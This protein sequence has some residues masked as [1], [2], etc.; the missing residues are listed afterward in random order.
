MSHTKP[1][2]GAEDQHARLAEEITS[3]NSLKEAPLRRDVR[4]LGRILGMVLQEQEGEAL[5]NQVEELRKLAT[6][7]RESLDDTDAADEEA[8]LEIEKFVAQLSVDET[9]RI[10]KAFSTYFE[11]TNLAETNHRKRRLRAARVIS[12]KSAPPGSMDG[13]LER[14]KRS[15]MTPEDALQWLSKVMVIPTFTAHPT[16]VAR[17]TVLY[18][19]RQIAHQIEQIDWFPLTDQEAS[20]REEAITA[21]VTELWQ[22]DEVRRRAPI[23]RDE[24]RM[25]LDY[26]PHALIATI[27]Q[28]YRTIANS[29]RAVYDYEV[30][31]SQLPQVVKFGSWIGGD[32]DGNPNVTPESTREALQ[33]ARQT[34]IAHYIIQLEALIEQISTSLQRTGISEEFRAKYEEYADS[35]RLPEH[36]VRTRSQ[37]ELYRHFFSHVRQKLVATLNA[38]NNGCYMSAKE[39][40]DDLQLASDSL[41]AFNGKRLSDFHIAPLIRQVQTFGFHLH[42]LDIRQHARVH[43]KAIAELTNGNA[44]TLPSPSLPSPPSD[45]TAR[46]LET[47]RTIADLKRNYPPESITQYV[48]SGAQSRQDVLSLIWLMQSCSIQVS[49]TPNDPGIMPVPLFESIADLRN[50]PKI[51]R[52][53][54]QD[55]DFA[56][57]L[58]SWGRKQEVMLGYSDSNKDGGM[59]TSTWEIFKAHRDLHIAARECDVKLRLFHGRG[60]TVGRGGGPTHRAITAQP[61]GGFEG[62]LR[63]TEQGEVLNWKYADS[64][65]AGRNLEL[66]VAAGLEALTR[67]GGWGAAIHQE[68]ESTMD[69]LSQ[70]A[71][72]YYRE[73]IVDNPDVLTYFEQATPVGELENARIGSRPSRRS[74]RTNLEDLRAIP[75]VFGWMQSRHVTP[76]YFGVGYALQ[77]FY[78]SNGKA[79]LELFQ[80]MLLQFPLFEDLI[81]NVE[82]ALAKADL[83]IAHRYAALV[84]DDK[85]RESVYTLLADELLR[86]K[87]M[88]LL[89]TGQKYLLENNHTLTNSI[90]LRNPYIDPMSVI[91]GELLRRKR[92]G[93]GSEELN[94]SLGSTING[95]SSGLRNTG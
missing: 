51:C 93:Q 33:M 73:N 69:T 56:P 84:S 83:R 47:L 88:L 82:T 6:Q 23:V 35:S 25:G 55:P 19:R 41:N 24:I 21:A 91:Q 3:D 18:K 20:E 85:V 34:V 62:E 58:N 79:A 71:F 87:E 10:T 59:L 2:W 78:N 54:W 17:R 14:L 89:I 72:N 66:M 46:L 36:L 70:L 29:F 90:K 61:P 81:R 4:C 30:E 86:T 39:F 27:P 1:L 15:G 37:D 5:Y 76:A 44:T 74:A 38:D 7:Y 13:T 32:R 28:L 94:Y 8:L 31:P 45:E 49:A 92:L 68:W 77:E 16:E 65:V 60:G 9:Y 67:K 42:T 80:T 50:C 57:L 11:L 52:E 48:I 12:S 64:L 63:I 95:I 43:A 26:Y 75:W 40:A 22:T 53:L